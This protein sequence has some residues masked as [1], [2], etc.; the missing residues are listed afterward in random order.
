MHRF[1]LTNSI[2]MNEVIF[3]LENGMASILSP[4]GSVGTKVEI[5]QSK[6][7]IFAAYPLSCPSITLEL[8]SLFSPASQASAAMVIHDSTTNKTRV[9]ALTDGE[10][11]ISDQQD[12]KLLLLKVVR[13]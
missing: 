2:A 13:L 12:K 9:F 11:S 6:I 5:P 3:K 4:P 8:T 7:S 10:F 1:E